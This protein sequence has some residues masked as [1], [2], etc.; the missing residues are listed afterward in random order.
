MI[1]DKIANVRRRL[2]GV[3]S[4]AKYTGWHE[5]QLSRLRFQFV[6]R[7]FSCRIRTFSC[8]MRAD[9]NRCEHQEP[10]PAEPEFGEDME[11]S[12][13]EDVNTLAGKLER[14][15]KDLRNTGGLGKE[16]LGTP[17][18]LSA[19][20]FKPLEDVLSTLRSIEII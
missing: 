1:H 8:R 7:T 4:V 11:I 10:D 19:G 15:A 2:L 18:W 5:L 14:K 3:K 16:G 9:D 6:I 13:R 20:H 17:A 12:F